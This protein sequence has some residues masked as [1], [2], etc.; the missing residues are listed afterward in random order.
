V[1]PALVEGFRSAG[2]DV[3]FEFDLRVQLSPGL[4]LTTY[5]VVQEALTNALKHGGAGPVEVRIRTGSDLHICIA[6]D[7]AAGGPRLPSGGNGLAGMRERVEVYG[8]SLSTQSDARRF[9]VEA[10]LPLARLEVMA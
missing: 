8:G 3:R 2:L 10:V 5:R 9:R 4:G 7:I 6:N 1:L